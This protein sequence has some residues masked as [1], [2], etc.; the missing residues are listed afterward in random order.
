M[1]I[2]VMSQTIYGDKVS[3]E[4]DNYACAQLA[5]DEAL[6]LQEEEIRVCV[7]VKQQER[8]QVFI[9]DFFTQ[10]KS[11]G[12]WLGF[13]Y[14]VRQLWWKGGGFCRL[15]IL[16]VWWQTTMNWGKTIDFSGWVWYNRRVKRLREPRK[17][18][19]KNFQKFAKK[20]LTFCE[21]CAII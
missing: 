8:Q 21:T 15:F 1:K 18:K 19:L 14:A 9:P 20:H 7:A 12:D 13:V 16:V 6:D 4:C 2:V 10:V 3:R 17:E 5:V 11:V